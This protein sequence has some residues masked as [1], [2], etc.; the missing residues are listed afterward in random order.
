M[1]ST[2]FVCLFVILVSAM[3][4]AQS[5]PVPL[6]NQPLVPGSAAPGSS[7]FALTVNGTGFASG[8]VVNWNGSP[9]VT[10]LNSSSSLQATIG[11]ADVAMAGTAS[12]TVAN[13]A[14]GGGTSNVVYFPIQ[15]KS[16]LVTFARFE[17]TLSAVG[18]TAVGDFNND[19]KLD[20]AVGTRNSRF[21][22]TVAVYLGNGNGTF[23]APIKTKSTIPIDVI[24]AG[25]FNGDGKL[26]LVVADSRGALGTVFLG[27]GDGTFT[28]K[29]PW[30]A[31]RIDA[32]AAADF[33]GDGNLDLYVATQG[34]P[35]NRFF[36]WL[37]NGDGTFSQSWVGPHPSGG[38]PAIGDF[39]GDGILDFAAGGWVFMG[40]GDGTFQKGV[41]Y[42]PKNGGSSVATADV[43]GDGKLDLITDGISV[44]LGN[45]DGTFQDAGG[46]PL[47][48][49]TSNVVIGDFNRD[50]K[51]DVVAKGFLVLGNGDGTF[52]NELPLPF[53]SSFENLGDF[54]GDGK[55]DLATSDK[56]NVFSLFLQDSVLLLPPSLTFASQEVG[57]TSPPQVVTL[58]NVASTALKIKSIGINGTDS[59]DFG[60]QNDCGT[61]VPAGANCTISVTFT[62]TAT[63]ARMAGV[64]VNY[65]GLGSPQTVPLSGTGTNAPTVSLTPASMTFSTQ[66]I[67]TTSAPQTATLTNTGTVPVNIS[68]IVASAPFAETNNCP[69]RLVKSCQIKV[70]FTPTSGGPANGMLSVTDDAVGSPQTV[71]LSG[72]GTVV[73]LAPISVNFGDQTVGTTSQPVPIQLNNLGTT[74]LSISQITITGTDAEDFNQTNNCGSSV[75]AGGS[76]TITV[77]FTPTAKGQRSAAVSVS[78]DGGG[79]PQMVPLTGTGT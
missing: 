6:I 54:N 51:L 22:G 56:A 67:N 40:N 38:N 26:D 41:A 15:E 72:T 29:T 68:S 7:G 2:R 14:P 50:G 61:S 9:R 34:P 52:G 19:G 46:V 69:H 28:E 27:N 32:M 64:K 25:D 49:S 63:G 77:T 44:L 48:G 65:Q 21:S 10:V 76:C 79:S 11:A 78:D 24:L 36:I 62:P 4:D 16:S 60:Q 31:G 75:P 17:H 45:G 35:E 66:V 8:A 23:R 42:N 74:T 20:V 1:T 5:N 39:N 57:T 12:V 43:N 3:L 59:G 58:T 18:V 55:L 47:S 53:A 13:P 73:Q 30:G 71:T 33:N 37:G 70:T